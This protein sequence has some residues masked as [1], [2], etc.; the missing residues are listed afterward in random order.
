[1]RTSV[2]IL[3]IGGLLLSFGAAY[4]QEDTTAHAVGRVGLSGVDKLAE[5]LSDPVVRIEDKVEAVRRLE[6]PT[7]KDVQASSLY[8]PIL[9]AMAKQNVNQHHVLREAA[10]QALIHFVN[11]DGSDKLLEPLGKVLA[12]SGEHEEV[13]LSAARTLAQFSRYGPQAT[14]QLIVALVAEVERGAQANNVNVVT[15][16]VQGLLNLRDKKGFVP[17]MRVIQSN[18]PTYTKREAQKALENIRWE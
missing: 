12:N 18:F 4:A 8:N 17:L 6:L 3:L 1:M 2:H 11:I 13:R 15:A 9:G 14:D 10:C 7:R 5:M 16:I